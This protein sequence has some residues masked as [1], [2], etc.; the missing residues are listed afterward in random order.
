V[1]SQRWE[2]LERR[3]KYGVDLGTY[4]GKNELK[5]QADTVAGEFKVEGLEDSNTY[6][7]SS[8]S[9]RTSRF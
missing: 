2:A 1:F 9:E 5:E 6:D 7:G 8:A 4:V 3:G